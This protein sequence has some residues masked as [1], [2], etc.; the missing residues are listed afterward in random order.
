[1]KI[2]DG[3]IIRQISDQTVAVPVGETSKSFH[4]MIKLNESG[5]FIWKALENDTTE[6][7]IIDAML[8]KYDVS[9]EQ[10]SN[11]VCQFIGALRNAGIIED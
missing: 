2:K 7:K 5:L 9:R 6:E 11:D 10:A 4:G 8:E 1:M 3:F